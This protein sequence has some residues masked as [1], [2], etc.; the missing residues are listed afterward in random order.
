MDI[1]RRYSL[2]ATAG[3]L[4]IA[5]LL[6]SVRARPTMS[7]GAATRLATAT[8]YYDSTIVLA[9][10]A[11]PR[12]IRGDELTISLG[13]LERLRLGLGSPFRLVDQA[14][15]DSRLDSV[16]GSRVAWAMLARLRRG[17]AYVVDPQVLDGS[18]PWSA[19]GRGA[20]G[21]AH[22]ALIDQAVRTAS[23]PRAGELGVRLAYLLASAQGT[24]APS[25]VAIATRVAALVRDRE[26]A[27]ADLRD[28]LADAGAGQGDVMSILNTRRDD[29]AFRVEQPPI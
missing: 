19:D 28:L 15:S 18:G 21:A 17:D 24:I 25:S 8:S 1:V 22:L 16:T 9:R 11:R 26:L 5:V 2:M 12:G 3:L 23:D 20:T 6:G 27:S 10:N 13:Y 7:Q 4:G 14:L 29:R